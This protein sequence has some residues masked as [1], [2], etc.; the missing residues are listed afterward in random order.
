[1]QTCAIQ[2]CRARADCERALLVATHPRRCVCCRCAVLGRSCS[3]NNRLTAIGP[4][5]SVY[6]GSSP[7]RLARCG[8][9]LP[10][11]HPRSALRIR[12]PRRANASL[13]FL[14]GSI[15]QVAAGAHHWRM[16]C[17]NACLS[18]TMSRSRSLQESPE[19]D[20]SGCNGCAVY[21]QVMATSC[22]HDCPQRGHV[23][24]PT[25][26]TTQGGYAHQR[27]LKP[28]SYGTDENESSGSIPSRRGRSAVSGLHRPLRHGRATVTCRSQEH[29]QRSCSGRAPVV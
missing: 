9:R 22:S 13:L 21:A 19:R 10:E 25:G 5:S 23:P 7:H 27:K 18:R 20:R 15:I 26:T 29:I 16:N 6:S 3:G 8:L 12:A 24:V 2:T 1:M 17:W 14:V 28:F 11:A 4:I